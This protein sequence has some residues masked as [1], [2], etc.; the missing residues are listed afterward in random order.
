MIR[1]RPP[2]PLILMVAAA[3]LLTACSAAVSGAPRVR[4][5]I[6]EPAKA[7]KLVVPAPYDTTNG[8]QADVRDRV[9]V[10]APKVGAL[11][12]VDG[13]GDIPSAQAKSRT[14]TKTAVIA[15]GASD[16]KVWWWSKPVLPLRDQSTPSLTLVTIRDVEYVVLVR[17]GTIPEDGLVRARRV[18]VTDSFVVTSSGRDVAPHQHLVRDV[19]ERLTEVPTRVGSG[20]VLFPDDTSSR[21]RGAIDKGVL[22]N[23]ET[24]ESTPVGVDGPTSRRCLLGA[25]CSMLSFPLLPTW[26]GMLNETWQA[27]PGQK[28]GTPPERCRSTYSRTN[29]CARG[30]EVA[31][32]WN[33]G[34]V[35]PQGR[36][37][38][39][40][41]SVTD[42]AVVAAWWTPAEGNTP[43]E[44]LYVVHDL[45]TGAAL[46]QVPCRTARDDKPDDQ[47]PLL[48]G[49]HSPDTRYLVVGPLAVD[50][51]G[52]AV[53]HS[54]D[55]R[56]NEVELASV[57]DTGIAY[58][59]IRS[60]A[61]RQRGTAGL[62]ALNVATGAIDTLPQGSRIPVAITASGVG[63]FETTREQLNKQVLTTLTMYPP[64]PTGSPPPP[65]KS[66]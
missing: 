50:M 66:R 27:A 53:C 7:P 2:L 48:V 40:P 43:Q 51:R 4:N 33:S 10:V 56:N 35:A 62:A 26:A 41:V 13:R 18:V 12:S 23:P 61:D 36:A 64:R 63:V 57:S 37:L 45:I 30:F 5:P 19:S 14:P 31:G 15:R 21:Q 25:T 34:S 54:Q 52:T 55:D 58:G 17:V 47:H 38:G 16:G 9:Y 28:T 1:R 49:R 65:T 44:V 3:L 59:T 22:W 8:W 60:S 46:A 29:P 42:T 32:R 11:I 24:G 39:V 20:G 6:A